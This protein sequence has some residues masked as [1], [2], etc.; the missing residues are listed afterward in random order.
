MHARIFLELLWSL[1]RTSVYIPE[2]K[3]NMVLTTCCI[4]LVNESLERIQ[5]ENLTSCMEDSRLNHL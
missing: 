1:H 5:N 3:K 4:H 2:E